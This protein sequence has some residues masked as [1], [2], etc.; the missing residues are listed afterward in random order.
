MYMPPAGVGTALAV[1]LAVAA[2]FGFSAS[3]QPTALLL[4]TGEQ[5]GY[6]EPCGC[7]KPQIGGLPRRATYLRGLSHEP[8][9]VIVDNGDMVVDPGRQ[10][11]LKA[12]ALALFY[13]STG[14]AAVNL[15]EEDYRLG[16]G[17]LRSLQA[18]AGMPFLSANVRI[19][20]RPA[21]QET[22]AAGGVTL[23]G[24]IAGSFAAEVQR[25]NP[26]L[27]VEAPEATLARLEPALRDAGR[28]VL[29]FHGPPEEARP[30]ARRFSWLAAIVTAHEA[31][32]A[33]AAPIIEAGVPL[34]NPGRKGKVVGR[35]EL[36]ASGVRQLA[37]A[38]LGPE[39]A[40]DA[41]T[42]ALMG[43]Y[44]TRVDREELLKRVPRLPAPD[45]RRFAGTTT[46]QSCHEGAHSVW[47]RSAHAE[48]FQTL[49]VA[50]HAN[51][52]DCVG[53]HVVGLNTAGGFRSPTETP[54]LKNV[55]CESCHG[56]GAAHA[57]APT[58]QKMPRTA[59]A[60][61]SQ[62]HVPEHSPTFDYRQ[63]WDKIRH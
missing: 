2:G 44:V 55:G 59:A 33:R 54:H 19:G 60:A 37:P 17:Y 20:E 49:V 1:L 41:A 9:P 32:D 3:S 26:M 63:F 5:R 45:G 4:Y 52:P 29:L 46:C 23:V 30:V 57:Q 27:R 34:V 58:V 53:C 62:C 38:S 42:R 22:A 11:Q 16:F 10:S 40:D 28:V 25:W 6:L 47:E 15:G 21:F 39:W 36:T 51:D 31:D 13:R 35:L 50:G 43:R 61:C 24:V 14:A 12:E 7:T 48:A 8:A 18:T 56:G